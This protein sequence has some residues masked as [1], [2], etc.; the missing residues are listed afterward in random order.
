[1]DIS[2][3]YYRTSNKYI[4][5]YLIER[6]IKHVE[7]ESNN[8]RAITFCFNEEEAER[9]VMNYLEGGMVKAKS[10]ASCLDI[11]SGIIKTQSKK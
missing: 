8:P 1:M 5:A 6:G 2:S 11:V 3:E 4:I 7:I 9:E 10:Y